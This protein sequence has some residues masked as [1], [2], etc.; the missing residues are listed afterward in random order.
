[1]E[2]SNENWSGTTNKG[3]RQHESYAPVNSAQFG[4]QYVRSTF[5]KGSSVFIESGEDL[6][7]NEKMN[8]KDFVVMEAKILKNRTFY[9]KY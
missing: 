6:Y 7:E 9:S 5:N 8:E 2:F 1:M 4:R 3:Q